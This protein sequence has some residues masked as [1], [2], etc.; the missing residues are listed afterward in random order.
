MNFDSK[1][2]ELG[3][4]CYQEI[5]GN[6]RCDIQVLYPL[7]KEP[8]VRGIPTVEQSLHVIFVALLWRPQD[9]TFLYVY[10]EYFHT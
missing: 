7:V 10:I 9:T 3:G 8:L 4:P 1:S 6:V 2:V 5:K